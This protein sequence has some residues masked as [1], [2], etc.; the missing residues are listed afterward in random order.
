[1]MNDDL[2]QSGPSSFGCV[3]RVLAAAV[4]LFVLGAAAVVLYRAWLGGF[5]TTLS[6]DAVNPRLSTSQRIYLELYLSQHAA[7]LQQPAGT[8]SGPTSFTIAPGEGAGTIAANLAAAGL[9]RNPELFLNYLSFYGLD[10]GLV[11]GTHQLD[12]QMT[13]PALA[14]ALGSG[15]ARALELSFLPGWRSE[16]MANY[17]RIVQPARIDADA[18]RA[19]V[20]T[21][22]GIDLGTFS[23]LGSHPD[24]ATLEGFLFP[25][26][27]AITPETT[28]AELIAMMLARF[29]EQVTP[30]LRQSF[31]AQDLSLRDA[32]ILAS[33]IEREAALDEEKPLMAGVFLNRL[34]AGMPL[35][36][37]ATVQYALGYQAE[38][39]TWWKAPLAAADLETDSPFNTYRIPGLPI[40]PIANP[41]RASLEAVAAPTV[42]DFL[43]FVL[44]CSSGTTGRHA[45]SVTYEE[46][47]ANVERCR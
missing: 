24:G 28:S 35:Q 20:R 7:E 18:F 17:L 10:G 36:A 30:G 16:E 3:V 9:L 21:G 1:M 44:D 19:S 13:I 2:P 11:A 6:Q 31:G 29:D 38:T 42:T 45:F 5:G 47:V 25:D 46:H 23:F 27:Y 43:Y 15:A 26:R 34:R 39:S 40:A 22:Q 32:V 8:G 37:D 12:P 14:E 41:G 4:I 33:I